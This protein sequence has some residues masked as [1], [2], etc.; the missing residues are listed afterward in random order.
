MRPAFIIDWDLP[1]RKFQLHIIAAAL[2]SCIAAAQE[3]ALYTPNRPPLIA[4]PYL[5]LPLG[6]IQ[7]EGWLREQLYRMRDG[8]TGH[9]DEHY[10]NVVG[11]RNGWLGGDGDGWERGPYWIDGLL[12]LAYIL[13]DARLI[14]KVQPWIEWSLTHQREDGYFGPIPLPAFTPEPGLQKGD[15]EDWWPKMVMLKVL[16]QYYNATADARVLNLMDRYFRFQWRQLPQQPLDHWTIWANRRG[17][18]NLLAV[19]WL[20]NLSG[21]SYL[22]ELADILFQQTFPWTRVFNNDDPTDLQLV[23]PDGTPW[24]YDK[25]RYPWQDEEIN[26]LSL[27]SL[28]TFHTV[29]LSQGIKQPAIYYQQHPDEKYLQAVRRAFR[30]L[31]RFHG[32]AQG[33]YGGDEPLHGNAP[34]QGVELCAVVEMMYSL[35]NLLSITG[36]GAFA[37]HLEQLAFNALPTQISDDFMT[38]Q[39]FQ[40]ANQVIIQRGRHNFYEDAH[41]GGTDLCFGI[42]TGYPCCTCNMHQG[43]PKLVQNLWYATPQGGVAALVY[44]PSR[45]RLRVAQGD[46]VDIMEVTAY[47]FEEQI[48]FSIRLKRPADFSFDLRIPA[49]C[50]DAAIWINDLPGPAAKGGEIVRMARTWRDGDRVKLRLPMAVRVSRWADAAVVIERGPLLY[51]SRISE[52]WRYV[53]SSEKWGSYYEVHPGEPWNYGLFEKVIHKPDAGFR[54]VVK[55]TRVNYPWSLQSAPIEL[56]TAG[57][58]IP[59]WQIY[60]GVAGPLPWSPQATTTEQP[61]EEIRLIPYGC[62]TLRIAEFPVVK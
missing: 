40:S 22:L 47:P 6:A 50:Q 58:R 23:F 14:T 49:W 8:L 17:G 35:E 1:V 54:V 41:H 42:L 36:D 57:K 60:Q 48:L 46:T 3:T 24:I 18:D 19:Y 29:N 12:P 53:E 15:R 2:L 44:A 62:T 20:Y 13:S 51:G 7:P 39:Y 11:S 52:E 30:D 5:E 28:R 55:D 27:Q 56:V 59:E 33:M 38:R 31:R 4:K 21:E 16:M 61:L 25:I 10:A 37:D 34:T 43:W 9:L 26:A 45:V 32:Q